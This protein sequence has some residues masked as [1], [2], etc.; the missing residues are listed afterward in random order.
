MKTNKELINK[1]LFKILSVNHSNEKVS[2]KLMNARILESVLI[3]STV[4][5]PHS[6]R[7]EQECSHSFIV[8]G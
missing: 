3:F 5:S 4:T 8:I 7:F 1:D 6:M 2:S